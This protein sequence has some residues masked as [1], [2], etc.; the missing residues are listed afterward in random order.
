MIVAIDGQALYTDYNFQDQC[1]MISVTR[2]RMILLFYHM[3]GQTDTGETRT[4]YRIYFA[5]FDDVFRGT[6]VIYGVTYLTKSGSTYLYYGIKMNGAYP[7]SITSV[8][9]EDRVSSTGTIK[10]TAIDNLG[11]L[12]VAEFI[13][14][15]T[16][17][18]FTQHGE[19]GL[20]FTIYQSNC[21]LGWPYVFDWVY[22]IPVEY[23]FN[24]NTSP[25]QLRVSYGELTDP[26]DYSVYVH[27]YTDTAI[28]SDTS[29]PWQ[30]INSSSV[31]YPY[32]QAIEYAT[33]AMVVKYSFG[34]I[35]WGF[36]NNQNFI[37]PGYFNE[38]SVISTSIPSPNGG[39]YAS[40][41]YLLQTN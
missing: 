33:F 26:E 10:G 3:Y 5:L 15:E 1:D 7:E 11:N 36:I 9:V 13:I 16:D 20:N 12:G 22:Y 4:V 30:S 19:P 38:R 31:Y 28:P 37:L 18:D 27:S 14:E 24:E 23:I 32:G 29:L 40:N 34:Y 25:P 39:N 41:I 8:N 2:G 21:I 6:G 35:A 17:L